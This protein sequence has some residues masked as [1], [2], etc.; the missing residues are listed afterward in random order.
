MS[1]DPVEAVRSEY[2][3]KAL[4]DGVKGALTR[5]R[6]LREPAMR[7][8]EQV[9]AGGLW[10]DLGCGPGTLT[11]HASERAE[12][13]LGIDFTREVLGNAEGARRHLGIDNACFAG[14]D[15]TRLGLQDNV[16]DAV[17]SEAAINLVPDK[18]QVFREAAR[19]LRPGGTLCISDAVTRENRCFEDDL[20]HRCVTGALTTGQTREVLLEAGFRVR[21]MEDITGVVRGLVESGLWPWPE[22]VENDLDYRIFSCVKDGD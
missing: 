4:T 12:R 5:K 1:F 8:V 11:F 6:N 18:E 9:P 14:M 2:R 20:W 19:V 3:D 17:V 22:F 21:H 16:V 15:M 7:L 13:I 10:L